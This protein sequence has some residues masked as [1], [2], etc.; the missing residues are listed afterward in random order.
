MNSRSFFVRFGDNFV[1]Q[2]SQ[3]LTTADLKLIAA[4]LCDNPFDGL[5]DSKIENLYRLEWMCDRDGLNEKYFIWYVAHDDA[6]CIE[7]IAFTAQK[8]ELPLD[9]NDRVSEKLTSR[10][11]RRLLR[12]MFAFSKLHRAWSEQDID[13]SDFIDFG[14]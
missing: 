12:I 2:S 7:V 8:D 5:N 1:R 14:F 6:N 4:I 11:V 13:E 10:L 3:I 9:P